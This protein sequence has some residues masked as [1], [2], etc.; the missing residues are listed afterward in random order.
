MKQQFVLFLMALL[1]MVASADESGICGGFGDNVTWS[2]VESTHTLTISGNGKMMMYA[3]GE[4]RDPWY[5][6]T[7]WDIR[8]RRSLYNLV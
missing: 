7:P 1:P 6:E 3:Y 8:F 2:Y 5:G 4:Y